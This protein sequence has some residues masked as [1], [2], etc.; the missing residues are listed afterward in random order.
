M[1][2]GKN[3][4][5]SNH[6]GDVDEPVAVKV[7]DLKKH[8]DELHNHF[9]NEEVAVLEKIKNANPENLLRL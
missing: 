3:E 2:K 1:Y 5:T 9:M 8:E 4:L 6:I 7:I